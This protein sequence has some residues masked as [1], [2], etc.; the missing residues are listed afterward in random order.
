[1]VGDRHALHRLL[2]VDHR[3]LRARALRTDR[4]SNALMELM[5]DG[6]GAVE[7]DEKQKDKIPK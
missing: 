5:P 1:M 6:K 7:W 4:V 3:R 2:P